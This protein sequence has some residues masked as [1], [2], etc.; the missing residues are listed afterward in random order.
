[1]IELAVATGWP[2]S[3]LDRLDDE[4]LATLVEVLGKRSKR[5]AHG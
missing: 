4:E 1:M 3:E 2:P 5:R